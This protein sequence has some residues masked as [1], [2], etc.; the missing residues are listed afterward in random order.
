VVVPVGGGGL[1][2][3]IAVVVKAIR[4]QARVAAVEPERAA[5]LG[6]ALA[7]GRPVPITPASVADGLNAPF[8]GALPVALCEELGVE[9]VT[10]GEEQIAAAFRFLYERAKLAVEPAGAVG[11]AALTSGALD[12]S[13]A[14]AVSVVVSGGNVDPRIASGIL[15][16]G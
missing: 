13:E 2:A 9:H 15:D 14:S 5:A 16:S 12:V 3:G 6:A 8:A 1:V 10:V 7:A 11:V 4:P